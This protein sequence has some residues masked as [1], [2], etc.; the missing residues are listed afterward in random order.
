MSNVKLE[1]KTNKKFMILSFLGIIMVVSGHTLNGDPIRL[2]NN[3]F[4]INSFFMPMFIFISGYFFK[5][6]NLDNPKKFFIKKFKNLL[7]YYFSWNIFYGII[8]KFLFM[9]GLS[10]NNVTL[11]L[12]TLF[13]SPFVDGQQFSLNAP[14]WFIP[15]L[16]TVEMLYWVIRK[17]S[18]KKIQNFFELIIFIILNI[19]SV[20]IAEN[21]NYNLSFLPILKV[22]FFMI[23]YILGHYYKIYYEKIDEKLYTPYILCLLIIINLFVIN[24][25][26]NINFSGLY[27]LSG[28]G[29]VACFVPLITGI[30]GIYFF[31]KISQVLTNSLGESKIVNLISNHTKDICMHHIFS[32]YFFSIIIY[33]INLIFPL[34][35]YDSTSFI[36]GTGWY[37]YYF[38]NSTFSF[39]YFLIGIFGSIGISKIENRFYNFCKRRKK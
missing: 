7:V 13:I 20:I 23:F 14:A 39:I 15:T 17:Y 3:F 1:N 29:S 38:N 30:T 34:P 9:I 33:L 10:S 21:G 25:Y 6:E 31:L 16:F 24:I 27:S 22:M 28:F 12:K 18:K 32:M 35:L 4:P 19:I 26:S 5:D 37:F 8:M 2:F 36:N 11:N